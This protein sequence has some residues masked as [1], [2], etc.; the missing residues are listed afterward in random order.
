[1]MLSQPRERECLCCY[2]ARMLAKV[3]C[4][5]S[6]RLALHYRDVA[7]PRASGLAQQLSRMGGYCDCEML[8]NSYGLR[9]PEE[10]VDTEV[11]ADSDVMPTCRG[12][13]A[14]S[15]EPC[16]NWVRVSHY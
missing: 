3:P 10:D 11:V 6:L 9:E 8:M 12:V 13:R 14:G 15:V 5:N 7:A 16:K 4:D 1:M 2:V